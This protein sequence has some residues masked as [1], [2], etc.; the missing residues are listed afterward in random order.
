MERGIRTSSGSPETVEEVAIFTDV[1][2]LCI[3]S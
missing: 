1:A 2:E 3:V